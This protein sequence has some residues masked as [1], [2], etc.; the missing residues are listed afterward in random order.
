MA[1]IFCKSPFFIRINEINQTETSIEVRIWNG[2]G[3]APATPTYLFSK[4]VPSS[5]NRETFYNISTYIEEFI[6]HNSYNN[7]LN[8]NT[9]TIPS[10]EWCNVYIKK[11]YK[12]TG[13]F[14]SCGEELYKSFDG[15]TFYTDGYN[16]DLGDILHDQGTYYYYYDPSANLTNDKLARYGTVGAVLEAGQTVKRTNLISGQSTSNTVSSSGVYELFRVNTS[17]ATSG[18]KLEIF[19]TKETFKGIGLLYSGYVIG[20]SKGRASGGIVNVSQPG[21]APNTWEVPSHNDWITLETYLGGFQASQGK[22]KAITLWSLPNINATDQVNFSVLP[23]GGVSVSDGAEYGELYTGA[24]FWTSTDIYTSG[25]YIREFN[26]DTIETSY[27]SQDK[28]YGYSIRLVRP[29]TVSEQALADG[30]TVTSYIGNNT[31]SHKA[32][33]IGTQVWTAVNLYDTKYNNGNLISTNIVFLTGW[34]TSYENWYDGANP[35]NPTAG[36]G[37]VKWS[38]I[39]KPKTECKYSPVVI[40]FINRYGAWQRE[41]F[42]KASQTNVSATNTTYNTLHST[43]YNYS[44]K[45]GQRKVFN[46]TMT[47]TLTCNSDWRDDSYAEVIRQIMISDRILVNDKPAKLVTQGTELFKQVNTKM[48]NYQLTF[49]FA[50]DINNTVI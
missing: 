17:Y 7:N 38:A 12:T 16:K 26:H 32:V 3:S 18:N 21:G 6:S 41:F 49:E 34:L 29:A 2:T 13:E 19:N 33:K 48:I 22:L 46:G 47:E 45:E 50:Y 4:L 31:V 24:N 37:S 23:S 5:A 39:F 44:T 15:K 9:Q 10:N 11:F 28:D 40:D 14:L 35:N 25:L 27:T 20:G 8:S 43:L 30:A 1:N 36:I 42:F